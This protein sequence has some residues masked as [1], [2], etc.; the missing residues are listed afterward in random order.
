MPWLNVRVPASSANLGPGFDSLALALGSY[1]T[2]T[3]LPASRFHVVSP[4][5]DGGRNLVEEAMH[6]VAEA[7]GRSLPSCRVEVASAIPVARGLGSS[8]AAIVGG[9]VA[10]NALL[11]APLTQ[12]ELLHLA[13]SLEGHGDNVAAALF[14]GAVLA[15]GTAD[16]P[17]AYQ[18]P[19]R[20]PLM[21]VLFI[22]HAHG[23]TSEA[24]AVLPHTVSR[25]V[26]VATAARCALLTL[27]LT[28]GQLELLREA[29][30]DELHQPYRA[31]LYPYLPEAIAVACNAGAFGAAL[32]GAGPAVIALTSNERVQQVAFA[33]REF[34]AQRDIP[35]DIAVLPVVEHGAQCH[36]LAERDVEPD[37]VNP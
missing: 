33:F 34:A 30:T 21:A 7:T 10:A 1:L 31:R 26:T 28:T 35:A 23:Y 13:W 24:R 19:L 12:R 8:A 14:G 3:V 2:V 29:M 37:T 18:I 5:P 15:Y 11:G 27:A 22:P 6:V 36:V 9:L 32:S 25:T 16:H 4:L 17:R 20:V